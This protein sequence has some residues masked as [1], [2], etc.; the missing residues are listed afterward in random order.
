[1]RPT[2][3]APLFALPLAVALA[4]CAA[5]DDETYVDSEAGMVD[6]E[7]AVAHVSH[8]AGP[9]GGQ[10]I[11]FAGDHSVH[12]EYVVA[13]GTATLYLYGADMKTPLNAERVRFLAFDAEDDDADLEFTASGMAEPGAG[14][15]AA[16]WALTDAAVPGGGVEEL[17]GEFL[18][19][20]DGEEYEGNLEHTDH[21]GHDAAH[22]DGALMDD[23]D[24]DG[25]LVTD[26]E[27]E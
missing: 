27:L 25:E 16:E 6:D 22:T 8:E 1:M 9:H 5:E 12:G 3:F 26:G 20:I 21:A 13:D 4:G 18:I 7:H 14:K 10:V 24:T 11:E 23:T 2:R 19:T 17:E 15:P